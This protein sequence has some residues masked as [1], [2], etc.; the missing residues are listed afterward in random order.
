MARDPPAL[1]RALFGYRRETVQ[2]LLLGRDAMFSRA[3]ERLRATE[4]ELARMKAD[5]RQAHVDLDHATRGTGAADEEN[6]RL[7]RE[8]EKAVT[9]LR[10]RDASDPSSADLEAVRA[11]LASQTRAAREAERRAAALD[12]EARSLREQ[13]QHKEEGRGPSEPLEE[14]TPVFDAAERTFGRLIEQARDQNAREL[15]EVA[16][17]RQQLEEESQRFVNW[18]DYVTALIG[19][20][21]E[22][23]ANART[24]TQHAPQR[25]QE[26]LAPTTQAMT[27]VNDTLAEFMHATDQQVHLT[28]APQQQPPEEPA[29]SPDEG[30]VESLP[31]DFGLQ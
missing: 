8:L 15:Q 9:E 10:T 22:A 17:A 28:H 7:R 21:R 6:K 26:A 19:S 1:K 27:S 23:V 13:L 3:Q 30:D 11:E 4:E 24:Q 2:Q 5:L 25:L 16:K 12:A 29:A 18:R 14:L 20:V 31:R